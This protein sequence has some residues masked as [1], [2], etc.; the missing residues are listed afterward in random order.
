MNKEG[1]ANPSLYN[2][3]KG[4]NKNLCVLGEDAK[5]SKDE[6][7]GIVIFERGKAREMVA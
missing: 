2:V 6:S 5:Q 3:Q 4:H 1:Q 7:W